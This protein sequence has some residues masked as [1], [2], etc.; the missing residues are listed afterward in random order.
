MTAGDTLTPALF[1]RLL[2]EEYA[3]LLAAGNR[4]VHDDSKATTLPIARDIVEAYVPADAKPGWY[5]DLLNLNLGNE[6]PLVARG[7]VAAYLEA[8]ARDGTRLTANPDS[9]GLTAFN[10]PN[11]TPRARSRMAR[12]RASRPVRP[13]RAGRTALPRGPAT[14]PPASASMM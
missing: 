9:R 3:K 7:R 6:D 4:D 12:P 8:I 1:A 14:R 11:A 13:K 10:A 5:I 2:D